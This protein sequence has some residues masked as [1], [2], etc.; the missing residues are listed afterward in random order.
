MADAQTDSSHA[1]RYLRILAIAAVVVFA[2][3]VFSNND[4]DLDLWG[5]LRFARALPGS[6]DF[7]TTNSFSYTEPGRPWVNHEWGAEWLMYQTWNVGGNSGL[8]G[9]KLLLGLSVLGLMYASMRHNTTNGALHFLLTILIISTMGYGFSTRPHHF[10]YLMSAVFLLVL[11]RYPRSRLGMLVGIP[12]GG[13]FWMHLHGAFFIGLVLLLAVTATRT[14]TS[15]LR[16]DAAEREAAMLASGATLLFGGLTFLN[17]Y[18]ARL[19]SFIAESGANA[20]PY[21]SEWAPFNL[22]RDFLDHPDFV[23]LSA[24]ALATLCLSKARREPTALTLVTLSLTAAL[25]M[26]RNIPLF[27]ITAGFVLPQHLDSLAGATLSR[28]ATR[29]PA[30]VRAGVLVLFIPFSVWTGITFDKTNALQ[31]EVN[32][33]EIAVD[34]VD[35][36]QRHNL[37]GNMIVFFDWAEYCIW[38]LYPSSKVFI[39]GRLFSAYSENTARVYLDFIY[40]TGNPEAALTDYTTDTVLIHRG[41]PAYHSML[42]RGGWSLVYEDHIAALFV[43]ETKRLEAE[44]PATTHHPDP[45]TLVGPIYF[46]GLG[47]QL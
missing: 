33:N 10:T 1:P 3:Q 24:I 14:L 7:L 21:L 46:P 19:W 40:N 47:K 8:L 11:T 43:T 37:T 36:I 15:F 28:M 18:G 34:A 29:I 4:A 41:N 31:I 26:R 17:P 38:H 35:F 39:D 2:L 12:I 5:N 23:V 27:A 13:W 42:T 22:S 16:H 6:P 9:L 44:L 32:R 45:S 20:R 30:S 25:I